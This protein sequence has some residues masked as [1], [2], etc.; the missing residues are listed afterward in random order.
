MPT[1]R[2]ILNW[3][4][5]LNYVYPRTFMSTLY[6]EYVHKNTIAAAVAQSVRAFA[7]QAKGWVV[8]SQPQ[9]T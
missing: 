2:D 7:P 5:N 1:W 4:N 9:Q 8:E 3:W 6:L